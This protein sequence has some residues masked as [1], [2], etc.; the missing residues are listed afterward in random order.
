MSIPSI[1]ILLQEKEDVKP[2][3]EMQVNDSTTEVKV[4]NSDEQ[5][6]EEE[7]GPEPEGEYQVMDAIDD[8][9]CAENDLKTE[10]IHVNY[11]ILS[12]S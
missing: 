3:V 6:A 12:T 11:E 1:C 9:E 5:M 8:S 7:G 2:D 10:G 4:E